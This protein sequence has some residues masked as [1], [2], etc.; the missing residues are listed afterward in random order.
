M[1]PARTAKDHLEDQLA[2]AALSGDDRLI[3]LTLI[4]AVDEGGYMR[5]DLAEVAH[6]LGCDVA[7]VQRVLTERHRASIPSASAP[8]TWR[9][10]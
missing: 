5:A 1:W 2:I 6:R 7:A 3:C 9:N 8:A 10:V 4:D